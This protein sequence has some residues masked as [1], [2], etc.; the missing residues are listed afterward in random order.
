M[1]GSGAFGNST[2][3]VIVDIMFMLKTDSWLIKHD[4]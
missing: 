1:G 2:T 4:F 3:D